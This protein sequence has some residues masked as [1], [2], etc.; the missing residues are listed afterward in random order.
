MDTKPPVQV[1]PASASGIVEDDSMQR[2]VRRLAVVPIT[3]DEANQL[4]GRWHRHHRRVPGHK[5]SIGLSDGSALRGAVVVGRP[6][7]RVLDDG[8]TLEVNRCVTD[9]V[10]NGCSMLYSAAWRAA[11]AMGYKRLITY[12]LP[13]EGGAS[14]RG[15]GWRLVARV[16]GG[17]WNCPSRPRV[18]KSPTQEKLRWE[19]PNGGFC[20]AG[21]KGS[22]P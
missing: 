13:Q 21:G 17:S 5:F 2:L 14:L 6:V 19:A 22:Q 3:L 11:R 7:S 10:S 9:G 16:N 20:D 4:V 12:T 1:P 18:D 15:A 8:W